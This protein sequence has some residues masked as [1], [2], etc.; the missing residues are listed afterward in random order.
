MG[1]WQKDLHPVP[2]TVAVVTV[3]AAAM[4]K[5]TV[6]RRLRTQTRL[7][8]QTHAQISAFARSVSCLRF[9]CLSSARQ[10][11]LLVTQNRHCG[12]GVCVCVRE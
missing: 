8:A 11:P 7:Q 12:G 1:G 2:E 10:G 9:L 4:M 3:S 5:V 6:Q